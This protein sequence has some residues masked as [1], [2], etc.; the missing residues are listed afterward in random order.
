MAFSVL[1]IGSNLGDRELNLAGAFE[2]LELL[3]DTSIVAISSVYETTPVEVSSKQNNFLN[4]CVRI[5]TGLSPNE[6][7][8]HTMEIEKD[9]GRVRLEY[10]GA[11]TLDIDILFYDDLIIKTNTLTVPHPGIRNRAFVL[12]PLYDLFPGCCVGSFNFRED[13]EKIDKSEIW[14]YK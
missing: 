5:E 10:H 13:L 4:C 12:C 1:S 11:R 7:L 6:L 3:P 8:E 9:M 14:L 2:K